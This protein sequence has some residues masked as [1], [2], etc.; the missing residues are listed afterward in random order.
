MADSLKY[1]KLKIR[2]LTLIPET[3]RTRVDLPCATWPIVPMFYVAYLEIISG[4]NAFTFEISKASRD[5]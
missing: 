5:C 3:A 2:L 1:L 4:D